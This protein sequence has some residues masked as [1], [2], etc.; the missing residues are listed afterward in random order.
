MIHVVFS[1]W[2]IERT[3]QGAKEQV[4]LDDFGVRQYQPLIRHLILIFY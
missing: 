2:H 1:R 4:G 3:F